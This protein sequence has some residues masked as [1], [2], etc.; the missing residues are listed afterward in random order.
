MKLRVQSIEPLSP[1]IKRIVLAGPALPPAAPGAHILLNIPG[2]GREW[3]NAYSLVSS[4]RE[5]YEIIVRRVQ[6]S[7]GG[8]AWLHDHAA[9]G[10]DIESGLPV[11]LFPIARL[12]RKHLLL[13]AGIGITPFLAYLPVL[14]QSGAAFELHHCCKPA[15]AEAF[16]ALLPESAGVTLHT[17]RNSLNLAKLLAAQKLGTHLYVCGPGEFM[18]VVT[19]A[20]QHAGWPMAKIHTESFGGATGGEPFR[21]HLARSGITV[22]VAA[23]TSLLEALEAAGIEAPCLCRGGACGM[24]ELPL[25]GG[26]ADHRDHVLSAEK[27]AAG[28]VILTCVSRARTPELVLDI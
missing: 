21:A 23:D 10:Q 9:V 22:E 15:E 26:I 3:K 5:H 11:N 16:A 24:C 6:K 8:S 20:A 19:Q 4:S 18:D 14:Q 28:Q 1:S 13:S 7:R 12:A 2:P 27:R 17:G 25:L